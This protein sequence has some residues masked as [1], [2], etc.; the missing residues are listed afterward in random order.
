LFLQHLKTQEETREGM[1]SLANSIQ[2]LAGQLKR[3]DEV[4]TSRELRSTMSEFPE[5]L[6]EVVDFIWR[7]LK[8]WMCMYQSI[9]MRP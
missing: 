5:I 9:E 2:V 8:S 7:W 3:L 6:Q 4:P 1:K